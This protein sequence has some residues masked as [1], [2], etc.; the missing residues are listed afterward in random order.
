MSGYSAHMKF[1]RL[2]IIHYGVLFSFFGDQYFTILC[3]LRFLNT[4]LF[5]CFI[6]YIF[7]GTKIMSGCFVNRYAMSNSK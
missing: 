6:S 7:S 4:E 5:F 2:P 1:V 3:V